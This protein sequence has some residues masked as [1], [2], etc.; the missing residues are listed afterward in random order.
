MS[1]TYN[2][3]SESILPNGQISPIT[4]KFL[5]DSGESALRY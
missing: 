1:R 4:V 2:Q 3:A 5:S